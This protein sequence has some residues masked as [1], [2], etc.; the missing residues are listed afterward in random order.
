MTFT[1][2][3]TKNDN[4]KCRVY[5]FPYAGGSAQSF[6]HLKPYANPAIELAA[7]QYPG[8]GNRFSEKPIDRCTDMAKAIAAEINQQTDKP[9]ILLGYSMGGC[10]AFETA[11]HLNADPIAIYL[12]ASCP[13]ATNT[14]YLLDDNAL[15]LE[16]EKIGGID[17][18]L[19]QD[20][21]MRRLILNLM[22][23]D[24]KI[25]DTYKPRPLISQS[26]IH[27]WA[28]RF[29]QHVPLSKAEN[30]QPYLPRPA[31]ITLVRG[32]HFFIKSSGRTIMEHL[33]KVARAATEL[34]LAS[35]Y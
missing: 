2:L 3:L 16:V 6:L 7:I 9:A 26:E 33:A 28:G 32:D 15:A 31:N 25:I 29:D 14:R 10:I 18:K 4:A 19:L 17:K 24:F 20:D 23:N 34:P 22:R 27:I 5:C 13:P 21:E 8:R 11:R 30:W 1:N 35:A 12:C